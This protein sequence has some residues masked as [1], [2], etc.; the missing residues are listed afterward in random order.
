MSSLKTLEI[1]NKAKV[2]FPSNVPD[3]VISDFVD[4]SEAANDAKSER[5]EQKRLLKEDKAVLDTT[6]TALETNS[7]YKKENK[8]EIKE[9]KA[10][11]HNYKNRFLVGSSKTRKSLKKELLA[12]TR[13]KATLKKKSKELKEKKKKTKR[14]ISGRRSTIKSLKTKIQT[15]K[16]KFERAT[17]SIQEQIRT[18]QVLKR[19]KNIFKTSDMNDPKFQTPEYQEMIAFYNNNKNNKISLDSAA[20][21]L[22]RPSPNLMALLSRELTAQRAEKAKRTIEGINTHV[23][24]VLHSPKQVLEYAQKGAAKK[25]QK[26]IEAFQVQPTLGP[27]RTPVLTGPTPPISPLPSGPSHDEDR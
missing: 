4:L 24:T 21:T 26:I 16:Q 14:T 15:A 1:L 9:K 7:E 25:F 23:Q 22:E 13:K 18:L 27:T 17:H 12:L 10:E 20:I 11:L 5:K 19:I 3:S 6:E 8:R 2:E